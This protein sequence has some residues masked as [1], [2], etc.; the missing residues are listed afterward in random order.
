MLIWMRLRAI[1]DLSWNQRKRKLWNS[2]SNE[3]MFSAC[4]QWALKKP[5]ISAIGF[6]EKQS[7]QLAVNLNSINLMH[8]LFLHLAAIAVDRE[9]AFEI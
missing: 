1:K 2:F 7:F 5:D 9:M 6:G 8:D 4:C 3:E